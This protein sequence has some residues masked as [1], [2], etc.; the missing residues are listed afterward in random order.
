MLDLAQ[1]WKAEQDDQP[2]A[3]E[4][5]LETES[6]DD[7]R[8]A[9][10]REFRSDEALERTVSSWEP[11]EDSGSVLRTGA[12]LLWNRDGLQVSDA[13]V[14]DEPAWRASTPATDEPRS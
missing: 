6:A 3:L 13:D 9:Q 4:I 14:D 8:I 1:R 10:L 7:K 12:R 11:H 5:L 2:W